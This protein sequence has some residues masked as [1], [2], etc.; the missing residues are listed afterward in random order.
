MPAGLID[1]TYALLSSYYRQPG[2][3]YGLGPAVG[4]ALRCTKRTNF[5]DRPQMR[6]RRNI[7]LY[8]PRGS[9]KS[10]IS[11]YCLFDVFGCVDILDPVHAPEVAA[12]T[13]PTVCTIASGSGFERARGTFSNEGHLMSPLFQESTWIYAPELLTA[14]GHKADE[15]AKRIEDFNS[16]LE[17]GSVRI[18]LAKAGNAD[19]EKRREV[20]RA[21]PE[22]AGYHYDPER[23]TVSYECSAAFIG[24]TRE[25]GDK[26]LAEL[27]QSG[28]WSRHAIEE[29]NPVSSEARSHADQKFGPPPHPDALAALKARWIDLWNTPFLRVEAPPQ[30]M[31]DDAV[32]WYNSRLRDIEEECEVPFK[33]LYSGRDDTD[34]AQLIT[35]A[36]INRLTRQRGAGDRS[37]IP[38]LTFEADDLQ[39][40]KRWLAGRL[41][42]LRSLHSAE[43]SERQAE[44]KDRAFGALSRFLKWAQSKG[45]SNLEQF[46]SR[47]FVKHFVDRGGGASTAKRHLT[48]LRK[49]GHVSPVRDSPGDYTVDH[50]ALEIMGIEVADEAP[51]AESAHVPHDDSP[52]ESVPYSRDPEEFEH[53]EE[54]I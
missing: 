13:L 29:W 23:A 17:E 8:G 41:S 12:R 47:D 19:I 28:Y 48:N 53:F 44:S 50:G 51:A 40:C 1:A 46:T 42:H 37:P 24:C 3:A 15:R 49:A 11:K 6:V 34:I 20:A 27:D 43:V 31:M 7:I 14:L 21:I 38:A 18:L 4:Q 36:S 26:M 32:Q 35:A 33:S 25:L 16:I 54:A 30:A 52:I 2:M 39:T 45:E 5:D 10:S 22:S 9:F